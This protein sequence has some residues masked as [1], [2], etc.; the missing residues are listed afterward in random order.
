MT[1]AAIAG[2]AVLG[3][4]CVAA[5]VL[6]GLGVLPVMRAQR[7]LKAALEHLA[8]TQR[9]AMDPQRLNAA[10]ARIAYDA[11]SAMELVERARQ[12]SA[13]IGV[14]LRYCALAFRAIRLLS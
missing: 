14:A 1:A 5:L 7:G 4:C 2:W 3:F 12:A 13:T 11:G 8:A 6:I 10:V 9:R